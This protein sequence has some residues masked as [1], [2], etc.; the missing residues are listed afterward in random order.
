MF[1]P[2]LTNTTGEMKMGVHSC[3]LFLGTPQGVGAIFALSRVLRMKATIFSGIYT[4][5]VNKSLYEVNWLCWM[6]HL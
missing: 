2:L 1:S 6:W 3:F 4:G 5:K